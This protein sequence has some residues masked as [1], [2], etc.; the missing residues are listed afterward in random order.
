MADSSAR[1]ITV[2]LC[3]VSSAA[4]YIAGVNVGED[5]AEPKV[6][7]KTKEQMIEVPVPVTEIIDLKMVV[8][9]ETKYVCDF[10]Q[11]NSPSKHAACEEV[12]Q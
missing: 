12:E 2:G 9:G 1:W 5:R 7:T 8:N 6:V 11:L 4:W 10:Y 3:I